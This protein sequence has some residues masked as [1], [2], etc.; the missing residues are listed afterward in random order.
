MVDSSKNHKFWVKYIKYLVEHPEAIEK[1]R[2]NL[3]RDMT[4]KYSMEKIAKERVEFYKKIVEDKQHS[5][6]S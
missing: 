3:R 1:I 6:L 5:V 4:E 2:T